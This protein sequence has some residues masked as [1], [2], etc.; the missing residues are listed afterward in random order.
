VIRRRLLLFETG[1][2]GAGLRTVAPVVSATLALAGGGVASAAAHPPHRR[3]ERVE[4]VQTTAGLYDRLTRLP[5]LEFRSSNSPRIPVIHVEDRIRYQRITGIG[6]AMTDS[7]AWLIRDRLGAGAQAELMNEL[8]GRSGIRL[9]FL[10]VPIGASDFTAQGQPYSYDDLPAG[11]TDPGLARFSIAHDQSYVIPALREVLAHNRRVLILANPWS[12]PAWMK[13]NGSLDNIFDAGNLLAGSYRPLADYFVRFIQAYAGA[14]IPIAAITPQNEPLASTSYPGLA[15]TA[16]DEAQ[17]IARDLRPALTAAGLQ[18]KIYGY[19]AGWE[20]TSYAQDLISSGARDAIDGLAWHCYSGIPDVMSAAHAL[21]PAL[22][23]IV[24]ECS[25]GIEAYP[26]AEIVIGSIRNWASAVALWNLALDP[27]GGPV[28][29]PNSGCGGCSGVVT[30]DGRSHRVTLNRSYYELGQVSRFVQRGAW[31]IASEHFVS[32]DY[33]GLGARAVTPGLDDVAFLN[34][35]GSR[36]LVAYNA[37]ARPM[38]FA[39]DWHGKSFT[40]R[41]VPRGTVTFVWRRR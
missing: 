18:T 40:Y 39:V 16:A 23:E 27:S 6:A 29:P 2:V 13:S 20:S 19:D 24:S 38:R 15:L 17:L 37:A 21:A 34:P 41:L 28:Q 36:V 30:I 7:S 10:R 8:F 12:P 35:D 22:D 11:E 31:R 5:D 32:Y 4:V 1:A 26:V 3:G 14:G 33:Q 25:P 9:S